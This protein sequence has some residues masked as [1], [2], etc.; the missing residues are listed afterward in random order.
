ML[1]RRRNLIYLAI[2]PEE[3]RILEN[4]AELLEPYKYV[5]TYLSAELYPTISALRPLFATIEAKL[6]PSDDFIAVKNV[7]SMSAVDMS[8]QYQDAGIISLLNKVSFL[9]PQ[10]KT[11]AHLSVHKQKKTV[12]TLSKN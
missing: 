10:F 4:I 12:I 8:T 2:S 1:H 9:D 11:L 5:T 7:K 3:W 6:P